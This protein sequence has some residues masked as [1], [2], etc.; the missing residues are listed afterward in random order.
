M[1]FTIFISSGTTYGSLVYNFF[2]LSTSTFKFKEAMSHNTPL[3]AVK[4]GSK[5]GQILIGGADY[6][7]GADYDFK[8]AKTDAST[9]MPLPIETDDPCF[10][11]LVERHGHPSIW[12]KRSEHASFEDTTKPIAMASLLSPKKNSYY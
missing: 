5:T 9:F 11:L 1:S 10:K 3:Y 2:F 8:A 12:P 4:I 7:L 6:S